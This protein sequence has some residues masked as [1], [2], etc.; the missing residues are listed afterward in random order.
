[1]WSPALYYVVSFFQT[2]VLTS[3]VHLYQPIWPNLC[4]IDLHH[5]IDGSEGLSTWKKIQNS[6]RFWG[7]FKNTGTLKLNF[8]TKPTFATQFRNLGGFFRI[9]GFLR[10]FAVD[11][12]DEDFSSR[13]PQYI[14][15]SRVAIIASQLFVQLVP[16]YVPRGKTKCSQL[17]VAF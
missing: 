14:I 11:S 12:V 3:N 15:S 13:Q 5:L 2:E 9:L 1:M 6:T 8:Y 7:F 16:F 17:K 10:I 4:P